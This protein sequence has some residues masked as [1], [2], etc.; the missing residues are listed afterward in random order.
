MR[1]VETLTPWI[2]RAVLM[3]STLAFVRI[4][5]RHILDPVGAAAAVGGTLNATMAV[6]TA[7]VGLGGFPI[8]IALFNLTC[9]MSPRRRAAGVR[10][11]AIVAF[12]V[13]AVRL[14]SAVV[15]GGA[16]QS[17]KLFIPESVILVGSVTGLVL[18][19]ARGGRES[20]G[21]PAAIKIEGP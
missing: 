19:R 4:G 6:T 16:P 14:Y 20:Q 17:T 5:L 11:V 18:E 12:T 10:L 8:A 3:M 21:S 7:R 13:I 9:L 1:R 15:D 2:H